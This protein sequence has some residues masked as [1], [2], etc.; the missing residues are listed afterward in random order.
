MHEEGQG[1]RLA[2]D[3]LAAAL[4]ADAPTTQERH[5][6]QAVLRDIEQRLRAEGP[7]EARSHPDRARQFAPFA[8]LKGYRELI[9]QMEAS[10][11]ERAE[12]EGLPVR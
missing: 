7:H 1:G 10:C 4:I 2:W 12:A 8:A 11:A 9:E 6:R 3:D 5:H